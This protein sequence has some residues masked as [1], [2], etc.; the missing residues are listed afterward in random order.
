MTDQEICTID[1]ECTDIGL[2]C[3]VY[4]DEN[5]ESCKNCNSL[6]YCKKRHAN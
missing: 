1:V 4:F 3:S 5:D 6:Y 2:R